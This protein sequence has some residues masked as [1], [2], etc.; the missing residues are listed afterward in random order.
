MQVVDLRA[1]RNAQPDPTPQRKRGP[2]DIEAVDLSDDELRDAIR[3]GRLRFGMADASGM[4]DTSTSLGEIRRR[5]GPDYPPGC[6]A[7]H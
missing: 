2:V 3:A 7:D 5:K 6:A 1:E 4:I